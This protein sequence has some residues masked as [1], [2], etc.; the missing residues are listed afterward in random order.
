MVVYQMETTVL[1]MAQVA[2]H[3]FR[4]ADR[5]VKESTATKTV[6]AVKKHAISLGQGHYSTVSAN[7][8]QSALLYVQMK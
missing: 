4:N 2:C 8:L 6:L 5:K 7:T 1:A 3:N